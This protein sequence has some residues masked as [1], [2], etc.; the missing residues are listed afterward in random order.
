MM[1]HTSV[2][3][4][5]YENK[6]FAI[7]SQAKESDYKRKKDGPDAANITPGPFY[8]I[9]ILPPLIL[10]GGFDL[11]STLVAELR[12]RR[13]FSLTVRALRL[14]LFRSALVAELCALL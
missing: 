11:R 5:S 2:F 1:K 10:T 13:D 7:L 9:D 14:F 8:E 12:A 4:A 6:T 3:V